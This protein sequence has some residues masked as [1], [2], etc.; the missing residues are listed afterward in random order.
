MLFNC[1]L[2]LR[3]CLLNMF[4][5]RKAGEDT[6]VWQAE[7]EGLYILCQKKSRFS[8]PIWRLTQSFLNLWRNYHISDNFHKSDIL[9]LCFMKDVILT[10]IKLYLCV[11]VNA[12]VCACMRSVHVYIHTY[13]H[14]YKALCSVYLYTL[15]SAFPRMMSSASIT[16]SIFTV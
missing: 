11:Y 5:P 16:D 3:V 9:F 2:Y 12:F 13:L 14:A 10:L 8:C 1:Y 7:R 6:H 15:W 4:S